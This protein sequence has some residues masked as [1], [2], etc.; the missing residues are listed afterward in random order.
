MRYYWKNVEEELPERTESYLVFVSIV[1]PLGIPYSACRVAY[2]IVPLQK[3]SV[4]ENEKVKVGPVEY[5]ME[6][7]EDPAEE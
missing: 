2:Y 7:P 3:W 1:D 4:I 6:L 5:W